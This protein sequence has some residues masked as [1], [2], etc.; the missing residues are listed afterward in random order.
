M[1]YIIGTGLWRGDDISVRGAALCRKCAY[2]YLDEYTRAFDPAELEALEGIIGKKMVRL[3]R[4]ELEE[5]LTFLNQAK[6]NDVALLVP[7]DPLVATTHITILMEARK[8]GVRVEVVH[9]STI[10]SAIVGE[11]GLHIYKVGGACTIPMREKCIRPYSTYDKIAE[12]CARGLHTVV[13]LDTSPEKQ[14]AVKEALEIMQE[15]ER[16]RGK[17]IFADTSRIVVGCRMGSQEQELAYATVDT[18]KEMRLPLPCT[19]IVPGK[20]HFSEEE[21]L[22]LISKG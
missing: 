1:L 22:A 21:A 3:G 19:L 5:G 6:D 7:G 14:L 9:G 4:H 20:L 2:V 11:A 18:L 17:G 16:E 12:N 15:I 8:R 13:F 10:H